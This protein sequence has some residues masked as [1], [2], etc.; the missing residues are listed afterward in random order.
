MFDIKTNFM[1]NILY[2]E[3]EPVILETIGDTL[4]TFFSCTLA[5]DGQEALDIFMDSPKKFDLIVT[6]INMPMMN[7]LELIELIRKMDK[8]IPVIITSAYF[9]QHF[10]LKAINLGINQYVLKPLDVI[11]LIKIILQVVEPI[12]LK[13]ENAR[14]ERKYQNQLLQQA[15]F[16]AIGELSAG[17]THEINT[18]LTY[19]KSALELIELEVDDLSN[20]DAK[21][22]IKE[23]LKIL[24]N[25]FNRIEN[26]IKSMKEITTS[27]DFE[28]EKINIYETLIVA[29][30]L[31]YNKSKYTS[32]V[33]INEKEFSFGKEEKLEYYV[34]A[35]KSKIEQVWIIL[36]NNAL[37]ELIKVENYESRRLWI[38][39]SQNEK[40]VLIKFKDNAGGI[41]EDILDKIFEPF[42]S[43]KKSSGMGIGLSIADK[44][45][46]SHNGKINVYNENNCAIF[47]VTIP[48]AES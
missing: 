12:I 5:Q 44:I 7:G 37:D 31:A 39:I 46:K 22:S 38:D 8:S 23:D 35:N 2:V 18:P 28:K 33:F 24:E 14:K 16:S 41:N 34:F 30:N 9:D 43:T 42:K 3:D 26:I 10:L 20:S 47:E 15:K 4:K 48:L 17:I 11:K 45:I 6:D 36:I 13:N 21:T 27:N 19:M 25:G 40:N 29:L 1:I 32:K